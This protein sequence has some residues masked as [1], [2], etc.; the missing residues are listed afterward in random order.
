MFTVFKKVLEQKEITPQ[1]ADK[2]SD[3]LLRRW[4]SGDNR[5]IELANTLNCLL[6]NIGKQS[7]LV[8][9]RGI[10]KALRG[11]IK[12]IKFP[13]GAKKDSTDV[14]FQDTLSKFFKISPKESIE[15]LEWMKMH[16]PDEL[17]TLKKICK[18][19]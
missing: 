10:S 2:V 11:Q 14:E 7:N 17:E 3:F 1:D 18:D 4:L 19:L 12:F 13:S 16:C 8:I 6:A 9:L 15:Y 5:L